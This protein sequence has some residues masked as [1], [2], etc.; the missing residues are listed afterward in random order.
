MKAL[1]T[2]AGGFCGKHLTALLEGSGVEVHAFTRAPVEGPRTHAVNPLDLDGMARVLERVRPDQVYH[3]AGTTVAKDTAE[4]YRINTLYGANL[5]RALEMAGLAQCPALLVGTS[6]EY[7]AVTRE[8]LPITEETEPRP[9]NHYGV[10]KLAQTLMGKLVAAQDHRP[11]V[12]VRP[13][14]ILGP[15]MPAHFSVKAFA[16]Q[17][18]GIVRG[19]QGPVVKVGNLA[20]TRDFIDVRDAA[21]IYRDL[22]GSARAWGEIVNVCSGRE[23]SLQGVLSGLIALSGVTATAAADAGRLK[24]VDVPA[25]YGSTEKLTRLL[26]SEPRLRALTD[27]LRDVLDEAAGEET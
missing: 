8:Q 2:G 20:T 7:G 12:I 4:Y 27:T 1:V 5:L 9:Y 3:L 11:V 21:A 15:G 6:A 26:G 16:R 23:T 25:H 22:L 14:N 18:A 10:S 24:A 19:T 17:V 13:F